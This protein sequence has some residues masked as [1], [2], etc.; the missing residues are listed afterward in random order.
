MAPNN[1]CDIVWCGPC[2]YCLK[3]WRRPA[4]TGFVGHCWVICIMHALSFIE[5]CHSLNWIKTP[6]LKMSKDASWTTGSS[7]F[8]TGPFPFADGDCMEWMGWRITLSTPYCN[9]LN[10]RTRKIHS[11]QIHLRRRRETERDRESSQRNE[12]Q[13]ER[14]EKTKALVALSLRH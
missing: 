13:S 1:L 14:S 2:C 6:W 9:S 4:C 5:T 7:G 8:I 12:G 3:P 10:G 11:S